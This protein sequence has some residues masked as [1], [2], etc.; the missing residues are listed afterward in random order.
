MSRRSRAPQREILPD[1]KFKSK[2]VSKFINHVMLNG[3]KAVAER[4]V[5]VAFSKFKEAQSK[6]NLKNEVEVFEKALGNVSPMVEVKSRRIGGATYQVPV[7]VSVRRQKTLAMRWII[8]VARKRKERT[9]GNRVACEILESVYGK[10]AAVKK[11]QDMHKMAEAN[12]AF[13]HFRW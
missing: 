3:K 7:E 13:A 5:Y 8:D 4:I 10:G 11:R 12:R 6:L 9:M 2:L 1:P